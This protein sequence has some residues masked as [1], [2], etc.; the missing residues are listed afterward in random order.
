MVKGPYDLGHPGGLGGMVDVVTK[1]PRGGWAG[2]LSLTYGSYDSVNVSG[3]LSYGAPRSDALA[4]YAYK[5]SQMPRSGDGRRLTEVY[6]ARTPSMSST[7][8][9]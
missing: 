2:D 4:G 5:S 9:C 3:V 6:P 1:K 8:P 7:R